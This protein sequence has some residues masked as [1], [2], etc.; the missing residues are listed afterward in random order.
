VLARG[1][2]RIVPRAMSNLN[3]TNQEI[4]EG[5]LNAWKSGNGQLLPIFQSYFA[6]E[7]F[8]CKSSGGN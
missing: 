7:T 3:A 2:S 5:V 4:I 6:S 1:L 8:S